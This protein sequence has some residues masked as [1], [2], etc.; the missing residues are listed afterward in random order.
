MF[1]YTFTAESEGEQI[2]KIGQDLAKL[3]SR[4]VSCFWLTGQIARF[5]EIQDFCS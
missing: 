2:L 5:W 1:H 4:R 3:W